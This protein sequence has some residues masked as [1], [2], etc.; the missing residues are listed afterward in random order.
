MRSKEGEED[1]ELF[2]SFPTVTDVLL[3]AH[4]GA[5]AVAC[6]MLRVSPPGRLV[7]H[8][9]LRGLRIFPLHF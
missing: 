1:F 3:V 5:V 4:G 9:V 6:C 8:G 2:L 7:A